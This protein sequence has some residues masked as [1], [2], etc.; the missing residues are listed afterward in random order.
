MPAG[1][2][3]ARKKNAPLAPFLGL[4]HLAA[5]EEGQPRTAWA[6]L[7]RTGDFYD[8]RYGDFSIAK[9]DLSSMLSNFKTGKYPQNPTE[10]A[11]DYNH[12][13]GRPASEDQGKASGW[14]KDLELR[15]KGDELWGLVEWTE[16]AASLIE[17]KEY[18]FVSATFSFDY[19][20][21]NGG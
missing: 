6:Q 14:L 21:S 4:I 9:A 19:T 17:S 7:A 10:L 15:D 16:R 8:P 13:T 1:L 12:G 2:T 18:R 5:K 3:S 11:F 20:N